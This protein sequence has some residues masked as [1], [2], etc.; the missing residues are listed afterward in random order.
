MEIK[1]QTATFIKP[2]NPINRHLI[3]L[4]RTSRQEP[5]KELS[6]LNKFILL[7]AL[8]FYSIFQLLVL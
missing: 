2:I 5:I 6:L 1:L 3:A 8:P 7:L 4:S